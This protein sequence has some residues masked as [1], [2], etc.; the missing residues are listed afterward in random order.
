MISSFRHDTRTI[1]ESAAFAEFLEIIGSTTTPS[2]TPPPEAKSQLSA[3]Y[4]PH[5]R[6]SVPNVIPLPIRPI[7]PNELSAIVEQPRLCP[8]PFQPNSKINPKRLSPLIV[9]TPGKFDI[10]QQK[11]SDF[12]VG[13]FFFLFFL[14]SLS[15]FSFFLFLSFNKQHLSRR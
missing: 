14:S 12:V 6:S 1:G 9:R 10:P 15:F 2:S 8:S 4:V 13:K 7:E 5:R 3:P 11:D